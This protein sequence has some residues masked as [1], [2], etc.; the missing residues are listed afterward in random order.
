LGIGI[1]GQEYQNAGLAAAALGQI[2]GFDKRM[3]AE[4]GHGVKI[5][6]ERGGGEQFASGLG[7]PQRQQAC[8]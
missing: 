3:L 1:L 2:V 8:D 4:I 5:E 6:I 7:M